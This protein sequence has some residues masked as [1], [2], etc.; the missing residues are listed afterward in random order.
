MIANVLPYA[1]GMEFK[2]T[3]KK[4]PTEAAIKKAQ[5]YTS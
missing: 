2:A 4:S 5:G 1:T 3:V